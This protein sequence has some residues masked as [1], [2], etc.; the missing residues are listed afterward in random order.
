MCG[1]Y[2]FVTR[3]REKKGHKKEKVEFREQK[4]LNDDDDGNGNK[5]IDVA[6]YT[7]RIGG[8]CAC[9]CV[10]QGRREGARYI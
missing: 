2:D 6:S 5:Y 10:A 1:L 4:R 9:G 3:K 8:R 7:G